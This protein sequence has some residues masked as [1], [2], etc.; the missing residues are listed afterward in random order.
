[1]FDGT[2]WHVIRQHIRV[3]PD[4]TNLPHLMEW[5]LNGQYQGISRARHPGSGVPYLYALEFGI[6]MNRFAPA[7]QHIWWAH[8]KIWT[9]DPGW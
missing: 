3:G 7:D 6:N 1:M 9:R 4:G 5:W 8:V 2:N